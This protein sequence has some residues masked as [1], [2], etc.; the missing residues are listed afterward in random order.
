MAAV[1]EVFFVRVELEGNPPE[2]TKQLRYAKEN[3]GRACASL[4]L[5]TSIGIYDER[6][7]LTRTIANGSD[8]DV[9]PEQLEFV[10]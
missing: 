9:P 5:V 2:M 3:V 7:I 6:G 1:N 10:A 4:S 8:P